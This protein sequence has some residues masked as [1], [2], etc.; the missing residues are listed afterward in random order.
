[1]L[2]TVVPLERVYHNFR[3]DDKPKLKSGDNNK[4][5]S[6]NTEYKE[7]MLEHGRVITRRDGENYIIEQ[8]NSTDMQDYLNEA[9]VPGKVMRN[10][11]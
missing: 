11:Q 8:I 3:E 5:E 4:Q 7:V 10:K 9:Y 1:M 2:Y 6:D